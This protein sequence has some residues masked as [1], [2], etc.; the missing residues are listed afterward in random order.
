M[1]A[2]DQFRAG[3]K[4]LGYADQITDS[5]IRYAAASE[6][7]ARRRQ[8]CDNLF[9]AVSGMTDSELKALEGGEQ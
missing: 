7:A 4:E 5:E 9:K 1:N 6:R 3:M 2:I 8:L